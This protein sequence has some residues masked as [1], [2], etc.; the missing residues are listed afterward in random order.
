MQASS[1]RSLNNRHGR[2]DALVY[3]LVII[4][5]STLLIGLTPSYDGL[6]IV[7]PVPVLLI[8]FRLAQGIS[9]GA[10]FG[11]ASTWVIEQA[12]RSSHRAFWSA[13]VAFALPI[14]LLLGFLPS[15]SLMSSQPFIVSGWR[16]LF[17]LGFVV[18]IVGMI[19]RTRTMDSF[20]FETGRST[21]ARLSGNPGLA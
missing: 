13:W 17:V 20:V 5:V 15:K 2:K 21:R 11:T 8:I 7:A 1:A 3:A 14:G 16:V 18:A 19:I 4:G 10:E 9:F 6:G 12:A